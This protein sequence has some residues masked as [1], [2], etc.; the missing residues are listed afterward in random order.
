MPGAVLGHVAPGARIER[1]ALVEGTRAVV[2]L[3][4]GD[5]VTRVGRIGIAAIAVIGDGDIADH[6][7]ARQQIAAGRNGQQVRVVET[8][9]GIEHRH[10][11]SCTAGRE[12]PRR[13][14]VDRRLHRTRGCPQVPLPHSRAVASHPVR[15]QRIVRGH[16]MMPALVRHGIFD[17]GFE[18]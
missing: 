9:T 16:E 6:V 13:L 2:G 15:I 10:H 12:A 17:I 18:R 11:D 14:D 5:P 1:H 4:G 8:H 7:I 3:G